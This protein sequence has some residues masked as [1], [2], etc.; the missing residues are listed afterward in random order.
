MGYRILFLTNPVTLSVKMEQLLIDNGKVTKIPLEDI[1]C[2][3]ADTLQCTVTTGLL[4]KFADYAITFYVTDRQHHPCGVVLPV[5]RHSRHMAVLQNHIGMTL[6]TTKKLW[7]QIVIQK[8]GNQAAA[9]KLNQVEGCQ[10]L[11]IIKRKVK[12]GD[13]ENMEAVVAAKYFKS[14]FGKSFT[15]S[16]EN[17]VNAALNYGYAILRG[18]I[19]KYLIVYGYEPSLGLFHKSELN[20]FNLADDLIEPYRPLVDLFV[21]R[22]A[23]EEEPLTTA[24]K[25]QLVDLLNADVIIDHKLYA[26]AKAIELTVSS[27]TSFIQGKRQDLALP[28]LTDLEHHRYE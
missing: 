5:S 26:C 11:D 25:A 21:K 8:I 15:R 27:L 23:E 14:L 9:M 1:E 17:G 4:S 18:T 24:R 7:K 12:P 28:S 6:P 20:Q 10:E 3:V 22:F 16:L 19:E 2:I 13:S